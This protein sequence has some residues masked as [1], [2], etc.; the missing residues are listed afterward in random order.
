MR[1]LE[2]DRA[3][4]AAKEAL[5]DHNWRHRG[6]QR[7]L[8]RA[9]VGRREGDAQKALPLRRSYI[10]SALVCSR[11]PKLVGAELG[12]ATSQMVVSNY[13]SFLDPRT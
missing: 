7:V 13:D 9:G 12:H 3:E 5:R 8:D 11:N 10:T 6:W 4:V 1:A 2:L